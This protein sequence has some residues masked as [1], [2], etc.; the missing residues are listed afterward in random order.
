VVFADI[1]PLTQNISIDSIRRLYNKNTKAIILVHLAGLSCDMDPIMDFVNEKN[2]YVI[3]DC[4]QAHGAKYNDKYVGTFGHIS[5][6]S[7]CQDKIISTGGEG[8]MVTTNNIMFYNKIWSYKD[9]GKNIQLI[10]SHI[11]S[12]SLPS[13]Q[14]KWIHDTLGSNYRMTEIQAAIG[15]ISLK[16]LNEWISI[17]RYNADKIM[18]ILDNFEF[19]RYYKPTS[20][21]FHCYYKFYFFV[22]KAI[23]DYILDNLDFASVG[24]CG[25]LYKEKVFNY[26]YSYVNCKSV[27][28]TCICIPVDPSVDIEDMCK[29]L[30]NILSITL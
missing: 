10:T 15:S 21:F 6:W 14:Y 3:E 17:R 12:L 11:S 4:A 7:F 25:E 23:R 20:K 29:K 26:D 5:A 1:D 22:D 16:Y 2:I 19:V 27:M 13:K 24:V 28:E 30:H 18:K 8:G 9:H